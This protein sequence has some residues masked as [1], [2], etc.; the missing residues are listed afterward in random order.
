[1]VLG[2]VV[3][4]GAVVVAAA[5]V[6]PVAVVPVT[7]L[8]TLVELAGTEVAAVL[9]SP[10][11]VVEREEPPHAPINRKAGNSARKVRRRLT[12]LA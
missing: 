8:D 6:T 11:G 10:C 4:A 5:V 7:V 12:F 1:V 9:D 2:A 3:D